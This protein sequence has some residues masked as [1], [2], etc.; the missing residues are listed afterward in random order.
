V[1]LSYHD[2]THWAER[3]NITEH[4]KV[5][6]LF[7]L[8]S[9]FGYHLQVTVWLKITLYSQEVIGIRMSFL[10]R[11]LDIDLMTGEAAFSPYPEAMARNYLGGRGFNLYHLDSAFS[12][13]I[14]PLSPQN[15]LAF[16]CGLL[17][18]TPVPTSS[19]VHVNAL[20]PQTGIL[21]SSNIG[22]F[23]G[24]RFRSLGIQTLLLRRRATRP[25]Y[26]YI[27]EDRVEI[28]DAAHLWGLDTQETQARIHEE[29]EDRGLKILTIGPAGENRAVFACII[30]GKDHAAGRTGMGAVM[31]S[32]NLKAIVLGKGHA[33]PRHRTKEKRAGKAYLQA[34]KSGVGY[35]EFTRYGGAGYVKAV[36]DLR[37]I[38]TRNFQSDHFEA[39][40]KIDGR[41]LKPDLTRYSGC[42]SCPI[43]C[44]ADLRFKTG[45]RKGYSGTRPEFEPMINLGAKCGLEDLQTLVYLDNLCSRLGVDSI[46]A[47]SAIAFVMDLHDRGMLSAEHAGG[48]DL[49]WGNGDTM[50][51]LIR[52][53]ASGE[54]LGG[55]LARG[56]LRA[57]EIL[58][59]ETERFA[60][61]VKGLEMSAYHPGRSMATALT[62]TVS[63]RGGD[64]NHIYQSIEYGWTPEQAQ[65]EFGTPKVVDIHAVEGKGR[66][67][68]RALL[69]NIALDCLGLCKVP[70]LSI[71]RTY[72]LKHEAALTAE[73][74]GWDLTP[75]DLFKAAQGIADLERRFNLRHGLSPAEDRLPDMFFNDPEPHLTRERMAAMRQEFYWAMGWDEE[76]RPRGDSPPK[77]PWETAEPVVGSRMN[78]YHHLKN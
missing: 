67:L 38:G 16:S 25:I 58:G 51:T 63:S 70:A 61:H 75:E 45:R 29:L 39:A 4:T 7:I 62:Y 46:S 74:T 6:S 9:T 17:T 27:H 55:I 19:R 77:A 59:P 10:G 64:Y 43:Q 35:A 8:D 54:K 60:P 57:A 30:S 50:E 44:K 32:K 69:V 68:R 72:D 76:G 5:T 12:G 23:A 33:A 15:I 52:Q 37:M 36:S 2:P 31:G 78:L 49:S 22:G 21:G 71:V 66:M 11:I 53:M 41:H 65:R 56:I 26:L 1:R 20:S 40:D 24:V 14:D 28:R 48:L 34:I 42:Y 13:F 3:R 47:G 73:L 18:G